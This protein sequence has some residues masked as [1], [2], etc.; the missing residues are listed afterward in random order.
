MCNAAVCRFCGTEDKPELLL[1][2][3]REGLTKCLN[4]GG[5]VDIHYATGE[6][7]VE[8]DR[9]VLIDED[10]E[11]IV[12]WTEEEIFKDASIVF[13]I[14]NAIRLMYERGPGFVKDWIGE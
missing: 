7:F 6:V 3:L 11:E 10:G 1:M 14:A 8:E 4:C 5:V 12:R 2:P 13:A 9:V